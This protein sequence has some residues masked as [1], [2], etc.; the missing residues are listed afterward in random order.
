MKAG[1]L[2]SDRSGLGCHAQRSPQERINLRCAARCQV[3][4]PHTNQSHRRPQSF[5]SREPP[6]C[7]LL[8]RTAWEPAPGC[9]GLRSE[10]T[11][12]P[13]PHTLR[14]SPS[15]SLL[16]RPRTTNQRPKGSSVL[17]F[18]PKHSATF[19]LPG[20]LPQCFYLIRQQSATCGKAPGSFEVIPIYFWLKLLVFSK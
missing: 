18:S 17:Y 3:F 4:E 19:L 2:F 9:A 6:F 12:L 20:T 7:A 14:H 5:P 8:E 11:G 15:G 1:T 13:A 10:G 16:Q